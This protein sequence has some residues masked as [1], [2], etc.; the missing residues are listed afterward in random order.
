MSNLKIPKGWE[1]SESLA[2][3]ESVF[4]NRREFIKGTATAALVTGALLS[5]CS[6]AGTFEAEVTL[7]EIEKKIYP[8]KR[9]EAFTLDRNLTAEKVAAQYNNFYEFTQDKASVY[10]HAKRL[11]TR[12][13]TIDIT[14]LVK[15]PQTFAIDDLLK[16]MPIEERLYRLRCVEAWAMAVPWTG[17]RL[18]SL[19]DKVEP[20]SKATHVRMTSFHKPFTAYG[21]LAFWEPWPYTEGLTLPEAMNE[22]TFMAVGVYGHPLPKQHGAP[23]RLVVPWKYGFKSIKSVVR[24]ELIDHKPKTFWNTLLPHEYGFFANVDP[25]V[26]HPRWSQYREEMIGTGELRATIPYNGYGKYVRP[27]Y[28]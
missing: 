5:G 10:M 17:F 23:I 1:I 25:A 11:A 27:M 20:L 12:P 7:N 19:L 4:M 15:K 2:T 6:P 9:N 28:A 13:W 22:L 16:T 8:A 26:P 3:P 24:I 21:Q 18:K 14:G